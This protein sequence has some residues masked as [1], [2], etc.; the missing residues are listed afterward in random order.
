MEEVRRSADGELCGF[1][2]ANPT[3]VMLALDHYAMPGV[4]TLW[5]SSA[6]I[7]EGSVQLRR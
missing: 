6:E 1:V 3:G 5:V 4:P 2:E 7:I